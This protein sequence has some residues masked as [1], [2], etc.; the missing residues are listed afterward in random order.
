MEATAVY[1]F[2]ML[3]VAIGEPTRVV[4]PQVAAEL[5]RHRVEG[6][7]FEAAMDAGSNWMFYGSGYSDERGRSAPTD[8]VHTRT[9]RSDPVDTRVVVNPQYGLG[10]VTFWERCPDATDPLRVKQRLG[11]DQTELRDRLAA[12]GLQWASSGRIFTF[13]A[14]Q[15]PTD[16][17]DALVEAHAGDVGSW[18]TGNVEDES[19]EALQRYARD[20][21]LSGR[22]FERF[23]LRWTDALALYDSTHADVVP[24]ATRLIRVIEACIIMRRLLREVAFEATSITAQVTPWGLPLLSTGWRRLEHLRRIVAE[25][26]LATT[27]A[28][29]IHS[30]EGQR[31]MDEALLRFDV[32][33]TSDHVRQSLAELERRLQW[34]RIRW[35]AIA[36]VL[37]FVV[38]LLLT[39]L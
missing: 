5:H 10:V 27:V 20:G 13:L 17:L 22:R 2:V 28:P 33:A 6:T 19:P 12:L 30:V 1:C 16:D 24:A 3:D 31:L 7:A 4:P 23:Y 8:V 15:V 32:Q 21:N 35:I 11:E 39:S 9:G 26:E 25:A 14:V 34:Q 37:A 29:P 36:G 38:N 18:F